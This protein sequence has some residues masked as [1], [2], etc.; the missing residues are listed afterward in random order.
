MPYADL[1]VIVRDALRWQ[2]RC[3]E[4]AQM[5]ASYNLTIA[6][7]MLNREAKGAVLLGADEGKG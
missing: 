5:S 4:G 2:F 6:H 7:D 3:F 1:S